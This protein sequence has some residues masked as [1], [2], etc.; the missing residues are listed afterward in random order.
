MQVQSTLGRRQLLKGILLWPL[1]FWV[2]LE[3]F[4]DFVRV[5]VFLCQCCLVGGQIDV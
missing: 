2:F 4:F 1:L 3:V 5:I